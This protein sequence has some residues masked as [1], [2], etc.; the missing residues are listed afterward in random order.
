[1]KKL[2][3]LFLIVACSTS[4][5]AQQKK[6][7]DIRKYKGDYSSSSQIYLSENP[8]E[9]DPVEEGTKLLII[10]FSLD[11]ESTDEQKE[12]YIANLL[13][14]ISQMAKG[15]KTPLEAVMIQVGEQIFLTRAEVNSTSDNRKKMAGMN[16]EKAWERLGPELN[17]SFPGVPYYA[18]NWNW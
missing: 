14:K 5:H 18:L 2:I 15:V 13:V 1:M 9:I 16:L 4:V 8:E 10:Q 17:K 3:L 11:P 6:F 7:K 12:A